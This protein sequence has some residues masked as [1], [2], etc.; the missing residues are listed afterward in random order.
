MTQKFVG[1]D[2]GE[3]RIGVSVSSDGLAGVASPVATIDRKVQDTWTS[4]GEIIGEYSP[5]VLVVGLPRNLDGQDTLQTAYTKEFA[6][7]LSK[8]FSGVTVVFQDEAG[9]SVRAKELLSSFNK[10][11]QKA[12]VD[13]LAA[14]LIL[15][16]YLNEGF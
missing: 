16:D 6:T 1:L 11:Y 8:R 7:E 9:T 12:D 13:A 15:E 10:K 5:S 14:C 3:R 4:I 2:V